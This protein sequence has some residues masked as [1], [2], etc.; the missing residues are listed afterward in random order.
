MKEKNSSKKDKPT[1]IIKGSSTLVDGAFGASLGATIAAGSTAALGFVAGS[2]I[3]VTAATPIVVA[4][5]GAA[6]GALTATLVKRK[7]TQDTTED[8]CA[9]PLSE[10]DQ[11]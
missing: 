10:N 4:S 2:T 7:K 3:V 11:S 5:L 6:V 8:I 1:K 9:A